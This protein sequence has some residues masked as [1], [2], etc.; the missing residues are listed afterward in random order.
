MIGKIKYVGVLSLAVMSLGNASSAQSIES[1]NPNQRAMLGYVY[2]RPIE[3]LVL[4]GDK[5]K[6]IA[7]A[8]EVLT[9]AVS[10]LPAP[11][12]EPIYG[13]QDPETGG[14]IVSHAPPNFSGNVL[15][16]I[17]SNW[18]E[19]AYDV[20]RDVTGRPIY[21]ERVPISSDVIGAKPEFSNFPTPVDKYDGEINSTNTI[22]IKNLNPN[23]MALM[24]ESIAKKKQ[25]RFSGH[26]LNGQTAKIKSYSASGW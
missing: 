8:P 13:Y 18:P 14:V 16:P 9:P 22:N 26:K 25:T 6:P 12:A 17:V 1:L 24:R 2:D 21:S 15:K 23:Q 4:P 19:P 10:N 7:P 5:F 11:L 20:E 3:R